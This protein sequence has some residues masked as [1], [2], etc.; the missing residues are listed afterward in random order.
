MALR[1]TGYGFM[2]MLK[3]IFYRSIMPKASSIHN[4]SYINIVGY[5]YI[6][7]MI[8]CSCSSSRNKVDDLS[9][10]I[11]QSTLMTYHLVLLCVY[12]N[13]NDNQSQ[14]INRI[15]YNVNQLIGSIDDS[16]DLYQQAI[17]I[18]QG[19]N[20]GYWK[21]ENKWMHAQ[22]GQDRL[23]SQLVSQ[24]KALESCTDK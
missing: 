6:Y 10:S 2:H 4:S 17:G 19:V 14:A 13:K 12:H 24:Q 9:V 15:P 11:N 1:E 23:I 16:K 7:N 3:T 8:V 5:I 21:V 20:V 22:A 18:K